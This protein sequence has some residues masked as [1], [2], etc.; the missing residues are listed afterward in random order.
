VDRLLGAIEILQ[1]DWDRAQAS[2]DAAE[3]TARREGMRWE[4]ALTLVSRADLELAR[5]GTGSAARARA[6]FAEAL[7]IFKAYGNEWEQKRTRGRLRDLPRQ[8]GEKLPQPAPAGLSRREVDVLKLL[9][10]G[11][12]NREIA[13]ELALSE[14]TVANHVTMIFNKTG[15]E[16]RAA[17]AAFATRQGLV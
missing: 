17:A 11:K 16:N 9:A 8:P 14:K 5:G 3:T 6:L 1:K 4:L 12:S 15:V 2:L 13:D 7:T 10:A